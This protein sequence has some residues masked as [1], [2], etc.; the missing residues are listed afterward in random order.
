M[1]P[2]AGSGPSSPRRFRP[3]VLEANLG[4]GLVLSG[5]DTQQGGQGFPVSAFLSPRTRSYSL[6]D[7]L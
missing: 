6:G 1:G 5:Q 4:R 7:N 2:V 3:E